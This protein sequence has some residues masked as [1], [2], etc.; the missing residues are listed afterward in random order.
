MTVCDLGHLMRAIEGRTLRNKSFL[1]MKKNVHLID[2]YVRWILAAALIIL[3][4]SGMI[5]GVW[6]WVALAVAAV[7]FVTGYAQ[8]CPIY[9]GLGL[10]TLKK[11]KK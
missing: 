7:F 1:I 11:E 9:M 3:S 5:A 10:S 4:A 8:T 2:R 6:M